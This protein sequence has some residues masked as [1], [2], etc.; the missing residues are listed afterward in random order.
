MVQVSKRLV[1][2]KEIPMDM[3]NNLAEMLD[4]AL[5][6]YYCK[7]NN[8]EKG[9]KIYREAISKLNQIERDKTINQYINYALQ[10]AQIKM[11]DKKWV[12]AIEIY[13]D[14]MRFSNF[15]ISIYKE[16]GLCLQSIQNPKLAFDFLKK[17][18]EKSN[19]ILDAYS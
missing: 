19:Q 12:E 17:F 6:E 15:P 7:N 8:F 4:V 10:Y 16:I 11:N 1:V 13:R 3:D 18:E 5:A 14:I 2:T 9:L